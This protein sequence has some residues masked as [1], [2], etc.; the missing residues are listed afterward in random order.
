MQSLGTNART[1]PVPAE[2]GI[3]NCLADSSEHVHSTA[4]PPEGHPLADVRASFGYVVVT[5][6]TLGLQE[7]AGRSLLRGPPSS[8]APS[9]RERTR[10]RDGPVLPGSY[11]PV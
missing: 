1:K 9:V 10:K 8:P 5:G 6:L 2:R 11:G 3:A 7:G 4:N